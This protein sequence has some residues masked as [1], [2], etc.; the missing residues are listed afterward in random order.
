VAANLNWLRYSFRCASVPEVHENLVKELKSFTRKPVSQVLAN[1]TNWIANSRS[2]CR[3]IY[4]SR[5]R[6]ASWSPTAEGFRTIFNRPSLSL[7][8]ISWR[9]SFG[10]AAWLLGMFALFEYIDTLPVSNRDLW[11]LRSGAPAFVM[12]ALA[13][14][15]RGS[16]L[17]LAL[18]AFI[19]SA[20]LG[21]FWILIASLG[22]V[23]TLPPLLDSIRTRAHSVSGSEELHTAAAAD[24][25]GRHPVRSLAGLH[26]LRVVVFLT[27]ALAFA[28]A[29]FAASLF[30]PSA[31]PHPAIAVLVS[32]TFSF[33][34]FLSVSCLNWLLSLA[35]IFVIRDGADS[36]GAIAAAIDLCRDRLGAVSAVGTWFGLAHLT[37]FVIATSVIG[38]PL[39]LLAIVPPGFVFLAMMLVTLVY[40]A[41]ADS[42]YIG[43]LAGYAAILE[44]PPT[45]V[46]GISN[47]TA[48]VPYPPFFPSEPLAQGPTAASSSAGAASM[49]DQT[50]L[51]L[52]D[53]PEAHTSPPL[54]DDTKL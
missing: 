42:L 51:I 46:T 41:I 22:R 5:I 7:A 3:L 31:D 28:G 19:V 35:T 37:F 40:F 17:R 43:R 53:Q 33:L 36:F 16:G 50:E 2:P 32:L 6:M 11:L 25:R 8:E 9:W 1:V 20:A 45:P 38:F 49:V 12:R 18:V 24:E 26:C 52:S 10:A 4:P 13:H 54:P 47:S 34:I 48:F 21:V 15:V 27:A 30:S 29:M 44:T 39:S 14:I 23:A